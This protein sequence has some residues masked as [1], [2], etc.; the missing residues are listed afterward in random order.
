MAMVL[1]NAN[2]LLQEAEQQGGVAQMQPGCIPLH[3]LDVQ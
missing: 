3:N 2:I 1:N